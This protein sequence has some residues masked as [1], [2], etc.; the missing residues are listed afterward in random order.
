[1]VTEGV[2][3]VKSSYILEDIGGLDTIWGYTVLS[4]GHILVQGSRLVITTLIVI[5]KEDQYRVVI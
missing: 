3:T 4:H 2:Y 5:F 1:M